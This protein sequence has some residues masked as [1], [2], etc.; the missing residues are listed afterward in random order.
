MVTNNDIYIYLNTNLICVLLCTIL[1]QNNTLSC[2]ILTQN[3]LLVITIMTLWQLAHLAAPVYGYLLLAFKKPRK[4][5]VASRSTSITY[6][7]ISYRT[8]PSTIWPIFSEFLIFCRL[9]SRAFRRVK[10]KQNMRNEEI[11]AILCEINVR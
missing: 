5:Q 7:R 8:V 10:Q 11:L 4:D 1:T 9:T 2:I 3:A 6:I